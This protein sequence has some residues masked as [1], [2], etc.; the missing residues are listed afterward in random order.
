MIDKEKL[1]FHPYNSLYNSKIQETVFDCGHK[2]L[3]DF[4]KENV[5]GYH[6]MN[7]AKTWL[8]VYNDEIIG[9]FTLSNDSIKLKLEE[10][11]SFPE[12]KQNLSEFPAVK[13]GRFGVDKKFQKQGVGTLCLE[14][15]SGIILRN[16]QEIGCRFITVDAKNDENSRKFYEKNEF[17]RNEVYKEKP[18]HVTVSYRFDLCNPPEKTGAE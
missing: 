3:N 8:V 1:S 14:V 6:K 4:L 2:E 5:E 7:L 9:Y 13:I 17:V 12:E 18:E 15:I 16:T 11:S 10:R